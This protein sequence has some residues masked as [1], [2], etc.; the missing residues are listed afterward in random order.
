MT[1]AKF[2]F[3]ALLLPALWLLGGCMISAEGELPDVEI[4][5]KD[6][7]IPAAPLEADGNDVPVAV[8]F[9][10]KPTRAGLPRSAFTDVR[11]LSVAITAKSGVGD[12]SFVKA[13]SVSATSAEATAAGFAPVEI[14]RFERTASDGAGPTLMVATE[15]PADITR[16]W[17]SN[18]VNFTLRAIGQMP[19]MAWTADVSVRFGATVTY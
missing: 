11:V 19:T 2:P 4:T 13:L 10:Q 14:A 18:E 15:P 7:A 1:S 8:T 3:P 12:L 6:V 9:K 5:E 16:L 17:Q